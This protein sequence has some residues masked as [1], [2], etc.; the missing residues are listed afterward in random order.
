MEQVAPLGP[1]YQA[2]TL[3]GNP[4]AVA[5]GLETLK[6]LQQPGVYDRLEQLGSRLE[7]ELV[8]AAQ[9]AHAPL[10]INRVGSML[11]SFF[12]PDPVS[13]WKAVTGSDTQL[14]ARFFHHMMERGVYMAPSA[15][16]SAF[17]SLAH[18]DQQLTEVGQIA[19]SF[20]QEIR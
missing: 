13:G 1:M 12:D 6:A 18:T 20:F 14:Y 15:F 19:K 5:A 2:G 4:L 10:T 8:S 17:I 11:T 16:E 7:K 9:Q 3:S